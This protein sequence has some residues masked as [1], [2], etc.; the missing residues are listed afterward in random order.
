MMAY[1]SREALFDIIC[2]LGGLLLQDLATEK[3]GPEYRQCETCRMWYPSIEPTCQFCLRIDEIYE[4]WRELEA[5]IRIYLRVNYGETSP[6]T[7]YNDHAIIWDVIYTEF[8]PRREE[9]KKLPINYICMFFKFSRRYNIAPSEDDRLCLLFAISDIVA[10][11]SESE[12]KDEIAF[13]IKSAYLSKFPMVR[14][15]QPTPAALDAPS[16]TDAAS[17]APPDLVTLDQVAAIV[18]R[19]KRSLERYK[20]N[21]S[22]PEPA[23][24]GGGGRPDLWEWKTIRPWLEMTFRI[25]LPDTFPASRRN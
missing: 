12:S 25:K 7:D 3:V 6:D 5:P 18:H 22:L 9:A 10:R 4:S 11:L 2:T 21:G 13:Y 14:V 17:D 19:S 15:I 1:L 24:K 8:G 23:V 20:T 16:G